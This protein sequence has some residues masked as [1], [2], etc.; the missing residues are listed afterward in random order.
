MAKMLK[1]SEQNQLEEL[2][3][4]LGEEEE[5]EKEKSEDKD[6]KDE[7]ATKKKDVAKPAQN[8][9]GKGNFHLSLYTAHFRT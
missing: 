4:E 5:K 9:I 6:K 2:K 3:E 1:D 8:N 7:P